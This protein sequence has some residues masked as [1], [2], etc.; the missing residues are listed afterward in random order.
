LSLDDD[1]VCDDDELADCSP[2]RSQTPRHGNHVGAPLSRPQ[3][4]PKHG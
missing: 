3:K 1:D 2:N 4:G